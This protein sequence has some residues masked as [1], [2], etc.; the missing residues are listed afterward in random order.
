MLDETL[1][2]GHRL[3]RHTLVVVHD[4]L[5]LASA[6]HAALLIDGVDRG[7]HPLEVFL[8]QERQ[9][10]GQAESDAELGWRRVAARPTPAGPATIN[11]IEASTVATV[12]GSS[13]GPPLW[14]DLLRLE[15]T[16]LGE[17][18]VLGRQ[19]LDA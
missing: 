15:G 19:P 7:A 10:A 14:G 3:G 4:Q 6:A 12:R 16:G 18:R 5:E 2:D 1:G 13:L 8:A 17:H 9:G 11:S